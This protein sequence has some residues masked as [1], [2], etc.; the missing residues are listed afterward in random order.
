MH[1]Y[2][3]FETRLYIS[4]SKNILFFYRGASL[5]FFSNMLPLKIV[6]WGFSSVPKFISTIHPTW[7]YTFLLSSMSWFGSFIGFP[8]DQVLQGTSIVWLAFQLSKVYWPFVFVWLNPWITRLL[9]WHAPRWA[10]LWRKCALVDHSSSHLLF[11]MIPEIKS[12]LLW[13]NTLA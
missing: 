5:S 3:C 2:F 1:E 8:Q 4:P 9:C 12:G 11:V 10:L 6:G 13:S 7:P